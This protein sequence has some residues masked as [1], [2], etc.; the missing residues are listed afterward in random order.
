M[1]IAIDKYFED[2]KGKV[3]INKKTG[4]IAYDKY[5]QPI[6]IDAEPLTV[7]GLALAIGF[8][9]RLALLNYQDKPEFMNTVLRAKAIVERYAESRL[10]DKDGAN[11]AKFSLANNFR[12]WRE[13]QEISSTNVN[14]NI[15]TEVPDDPAELKK[16]VQELSKE[17]K[18][19]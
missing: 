7:T 4:E 3:L 1:Q 6:I 13:K 15:N 11:G 2:C 5:G 12:D 19:D 9:T 8:N 17:L 16:M 14:A 18:M 10:F